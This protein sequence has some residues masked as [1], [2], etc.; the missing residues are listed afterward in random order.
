MFFSYMFK[1]H[2]QCVSDPFLV[3]SCKEANFWKFENQVR[4]SGACLI[5]APVGTDS[6]MVSIAVLNVPERN[7]MMK[8][9]AMV[10]PLDTCKHN[11]PGTPDA[12]PDGTVSFHA[13]S[14]ILGI[15]SWVK[16]HPFQHLVMPPNVNSVQG[17]CCDPLNCIFPE[18][19]C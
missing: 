17:I 14:I 15:Q 2:R 11:Q 19:Y 9:T 18:W 3:T 7:G 16:C 6:L 4:E 13:M 1:M 5:H 10:A 8:S 12:L